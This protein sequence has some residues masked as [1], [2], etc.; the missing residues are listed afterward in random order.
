[1]VVKVWCHDLEDIAR[2][3]RTRNLRHRM[4]FNKD[5][6]VGSVFSCHPDELFGSGVLVPLLYS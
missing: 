3:V 5:N 2:R 1:M 6:C 4:L